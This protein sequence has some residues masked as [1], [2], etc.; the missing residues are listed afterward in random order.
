MIGAWLANHKVPLL[1]A[2]LVYFIHASS[3]LWSEKYS[4]QFKTENPLVE[5]TRTVCTLQVFFYLSCGF[6]LK[7]RQ[8]CCY[9]ATDDAP[10]YAVLSPT[11]FCI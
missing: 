7:S 2:W 1:L 11:Q 6:S 3:S 10:S 9:M 4:V 5:W 8:N